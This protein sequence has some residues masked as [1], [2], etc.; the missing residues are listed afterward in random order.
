[1]FG[2]FPS[3]RGESWSGVCLSITAMSRI[4][5][6]L[7]KQDNRELRSPFS[8]I[9]FDRAECERRHYLQYR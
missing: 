3:A 4:Q 5:G 1:M 6:R 7:F 9:H 2:S 8:Q